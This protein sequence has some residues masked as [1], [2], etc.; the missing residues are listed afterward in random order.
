VNRCKPLATG[1]GTAAAAAAALPA[2]VRRLLPVFPA[3]A[4]AAAGGGA[5]R[6]ALVGPARYCIARHQLP[7]SSIH[8]GSNAWMTWRALSTEPYALVTFNVASCRL[9]SAVSAATAGVAA[10]AAADATR[11]HLAMA[12][13][14]HAGGTDQAFRWHAAAVVDVAAADAASA[15]VAAY[16]SVALHGAALDAGPCGEPEPT[17][18]GDYPELLR[19]AR[20]ALVQPSLGGGGSAGGAGAGGGGRGGA[21]E[22]M[23]EESE[24][25]EEEEEEGP[26]AAEARAGL[27]EAVGA[28][29]AKAVVEGPPERRAAC[30]GLLAAVLPA[31]AAAAARGTTATASTAT[32]V[33]APEAAAGWL[34]PFARLLWELKHHDSNTTARALHVLRAVAARTGGLNADD[35]LG[36]AL[37]GVESELAPFFA[38]VAPPPPTPEAPRAPAKPGPFA[39]LPLAACQ[40]PAI[41]LLGSLPSLSPATLRAVAYAVLA[42]G[43]DCTLAVR[44]VEAVACNLRAAPL[45]LSVSFLA[46]L[47][48]GAP[49]WAAAGAVAPAAARA[50]ASLGDAGSPWAGASLAWPAAA[51]VVTRANAG[52]DD[53]AARRA[54][55]GMLV[56]AAVAVEASAAADAISSGGEAASGTSESVSGGGGPAFAAPA[57]L[58]A[59]LPGIIADTLAT[60]AAAQLA[61]MGSVAAALSA[62]AGLAEGAAGGSD[63]RAAVCARLLLAAPR[64][65]APVLHA[66]ARR[67]AEAAE[68]VTAGGGGGGGKKAKAK[69]KS[70]GADKTEAGEEAEAGGEGAA[71]A[72]VAAVEGSSSAVGAMCGA[73]PA[74]QVLAAAEGVQAAVAALGA[75]ADA[76]VRAGLPG[77]PRAAKAARVAK[78]A[79]AGILGAGAARD[80]VAV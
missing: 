47:L 25:E 72:A 11:W 75:A 26:S 12:H 9:L 23:D 54:V 63:L 8:N 37:A 69:G 78:L 68:A 21:D 51:V 48:T 73:L 7:F 62:D 79:A 46:T 15:A 4:P 53:D 13:A 2:L 10:A 61:P 38:R 40:A 28:V 35:P 80:A 52:R 65:T 67:A 60:G 1:T 55:Y 20:G 45:A 41:M 33:L 32:P 49:D 17:A 19:L 18:E 71:E 16:L 22:D 42:P 29:W 31:A 44:A 6:R 24:E 66:L 76:L 57:E 14:G 77:A 74:P 3:V 50:L 30:V 70:K 39:R 43:R 58:E 64:W 27:V 34:R 36:S 59:E 56:A 5:E